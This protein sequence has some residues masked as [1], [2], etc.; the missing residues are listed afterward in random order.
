MTATAFDNPYVLT[1]EAGH[2]YVHVETGKAVPGVSSV[3]RKAGVRAVPMTSGTGRY[4]EAMR[5]GLQRGTEVHRLTRAMDETF[6]LADAFDDL[7]D[8]ADLTPQNVNY[9][10]AYDRFLRT[11][12][13]RPLAW[14]VIVYHAQARYAGRCDGVGW[15]GTKRILIDR[16]T[17][18]TLHRSVW[19]QLGAYREA[20]NYS[21]PH[22]KID[23]TFA[24]HLKADMSFELIPNPIEGEDFHYFTAALWL[25][26]WNESVL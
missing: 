9:V 15:L 10:A 14:E 23:Q 21:R 6:D 11:A 5:A 22:E 8:P 16:K 20:W 12:D 1:L 3:L 13:Y 4:A 17:D 25:A 7:F 18:R 24:L 19:L 26:R 2:R